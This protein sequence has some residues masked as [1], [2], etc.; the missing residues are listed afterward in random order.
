[1]GVNAAAACDDGAQSYPG[2]SAE[3]VNDNR[4]SDGALNR[5][6]SAAA[7]VVR[8]HEGPNVNEQRNIAEELATAQ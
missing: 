8:M 7:I 3:Y 5:Q 6:N 1:M 2:N 4:V